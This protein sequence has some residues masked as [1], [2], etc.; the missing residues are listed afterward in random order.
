MHRCHPSGRRTWTIQVCKGKFLCG[1][2]GE[3]QSAVVV[4]ATGFN[5]QSPLCSRPPGVVVVSI[6]G[7]STIKTVEI[8]KAE[9]LSSDSSRA[10]L[11][12]GPL[13]TMEAP[14]GWLMLVTRPSS[15]LAVSIHLSYVHLPSHPDR[16]N[17]VA[18]NAGGYLAL[19]FPPG[20]GNPL[21]ALV[22]ASQE[23]EM[24]QAKWSYSSYPFHVGFSGF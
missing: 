6:A 24:M 10:P 20:P 14:A 22:S 5:C 9:I 16:R 17:H 13:R 4:L 12:S 18:Q 23:P 7:H 1:G 8:C 19:L 15:L 3:V 21:W 2:G 11:Q